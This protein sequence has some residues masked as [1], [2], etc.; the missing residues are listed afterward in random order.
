VFLAAL[1]LGASIA[2]ASRAA[3]LSRDYLC[4]FASSSAELAYR[5]QR[6]VLDF[7]TFEFRAALLRMQRTEGPHGLDGASAAVSPPRV[8]LNGH[9]DRAEAVAGKARLGRMRAEAVAALLRRNGVPAEAITIESFGARRPVIPSAGAEP[10]NR[11]VQLV[12]R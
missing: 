12:I 9:I 5:C 1:V 10:Q 2:F 3:A 4:F 8:I 11:R 6:L 7:L